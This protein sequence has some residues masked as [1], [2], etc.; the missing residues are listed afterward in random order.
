M[1]LKLHTAF[2]KYFFG[3]IYKISACGRMSIWKFYQK[4]FWIRIRGW[5]Y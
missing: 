5:L 3:F 2:P 4:K 1:A